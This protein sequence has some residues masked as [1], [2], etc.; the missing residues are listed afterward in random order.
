MRAIE[1]NR[2][3]YGGPVGSVILFPLSDVAIFQSIYLT[4]VSGCLFSDSSAWKRSRSASRMIPGQSSD[5]PYQL[6]ANFQK[7]ST[8]GEI[9]KEQG[10]GSLAT[11][12]YQSGIKFHKC[13]ESC[14]LPI[15]CREQRRRRLHG[16]IDLIP[17]YT[18]TAKGTVNDGNIAK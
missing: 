4:L 11:P 3:R 5:V 7:K 8:S 17:E 18:K 14:H 13:H 16:L 6:P 9:L 15:P 1:E 2:S 12:S 10:W